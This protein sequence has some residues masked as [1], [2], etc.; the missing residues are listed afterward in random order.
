MRYFKV[1]IVFILISLVG[2]NKPG[3]E[4]TQLP[5]ETL[6]KIIN[7]GQQAAKTLVATLKSELM[8]AISKG[9]PVA[10][11]GICKNRAMVLTDSLAKASSL[12]INIRRTSFKYRNPVNAPDEVDGEVLRVYENAINSGKTPPQFQ[13]REITEH[14][15]LVWRYYHPMT[16]QAVCQTCHGSLDEMPEALRST[17]TAYYPDDRATGYEAG[18]FRGVIRVT[19]KESE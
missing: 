3:D 7:T 17:L 4:Q 9:G 18:D 8:N 11:I 19:I 1:L 5:P 2:C 14:G 13:I 6:N 10:A 16:V 12:V 15:K